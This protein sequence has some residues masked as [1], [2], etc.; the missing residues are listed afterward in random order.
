[1]TPAAIWGALIGAQILSLLLAWALLRAATR[2]DVDGEA[3]MR[4]ICAGRLSGD[5][6]CVVDAEGRIIA[7]NAPYAG[8]TGYTPGELQNTLLCALL[9]D[10]VDDP[11]TLDVIKTAFREHA[12][13]RTDM[14]YRARSGE[15][16]TMILELHP[17]HDR[18]KR[19]LGFGVVQID[20]DRQRH[21]SEETGRLL[22]H[23]QAVLDILDHYAIVSETD[24][25]GRIT[26]VNDEFIKLSGYSKAE[27]LGRPHSMLSSGHHDAQFW[28]EMWDTITQG[29]IWNNAVCNRAKNGELYWVHVAISPLLGPNGLPEKYVSI[30]LNITSLKVNRDLL[31]RTGQIARIGGWYAELGTQSVNFSREAVNILGLAFPGAVNIDDERALPDAWRELYTCIRKATAE[32][33]ALRRTLRIALPDGH[34]HAFRVAGEIEYLDGRPYRLIGAAQDITELLETRRRAQA[35]ER[36]LHSAIEALDEAFALYDAQEKLVFCNERYR[37]IAG[38]HGDRVVPGVSFEEVLRIGIE[39][40]A[41]LDA[42]HDPQAWLADQLQAMRGTHTSV[43]QHLRDGRWLDVITAVTEDGMRIRFCL[44]VTEMHRALDAAHMGMRSKSQFLA[45]MSHEIRTPMNAIIG[46][47]QLLRHAAVDVEQQDLLD[48]TNNAA[49]TLLAILNDILDFSKID[50]NQM[51]LSI[52]PFELDALLAELSVILSG[53]LGDRNLELIYDIDPDI[54]PVLRGDALRLKQVLMNLGSN[55]IKFT[56]SG[57]VVVRVRMLKLDASGA[58][59]EFAVEDTGIGI[60]AE[61]RPRIFNAFSQ[62]EASTSRRYGGTGLGLTISRR[63]IQLMLGQAGEGQDLDFESEPGRGSRFHFQILLPVEPYGTALSQPAAEMDAG[64]TA[65]LLEPH[66]H[67]AAALERMLA[68]MGWQVRI[69]RDA[70]A[71]QAVVRADVLDPRPRL[72]LLDLDTPQR[73]AF[74]DG[75]AALQ[76]NPPVLLTM[77]SRNL[78]VP[79]STLCKPV[80]AGMVL[81]A[82]GR[83]T[84]PGAA[85]NELPPAVQR[86]A[87]LHLLLV[88]DNSINQEVALRMLAREGAKV[89][90][91]AN[92]QLALDALDAEPHSYDLVLMDLHMPVLDGLQATR[93]IRRKPQ[94]VGLPIIAMTANAMESDR[95]ACLEAGMTDHIGKPFDLDKLVAIILQYTKGVQAPSARDITAPR[96]STAIMPILDAQ[97]G[98]TRVNHDDAFYARLL[99]D[100]TALAPAL[101]GKILDTQ[102]TDSTQIADAAHQLKSNAALVGALRLASVCESIEQT[103]RRA[104]ARV[105]DSDAR[106]SFEQTLSATLDAQNDWLTRHAQG[107]TPLS[108]PEDATPKAVDVEAGL[109]QLATHLAVCDMDSLDLFD[110]LTSRYGTTLSGPSWD[111]LQQAMAIF[112]TAAAIDAIHKLQKR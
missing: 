89:S 28:Q 1:M 58:L 71:L 64:T 51:Q 56:H 3:L 86:L 105:P 34:T 88:E 6:I 108:V 4:M 61:Q 27:L 35:S 22:R 90:V 17:M 10:S 46:M 48:K 30:H 33:K 43:H 77:S 50:A 67:S 5:A 60:S 84:T 87:G 81:T 109:D 100:F 59:L 53:N 14:R 47:L 11:A 98:L 8:L 57:E 96:S 94:H 13:I 104:P 65:W 20:I 76:D 52:E 7:T 36:T 75:L 40:N 78:N 38:T 54:P 79:R 103:L 49:H 19:L 106:Q 25:S 112:D 12:E 23:H 110:D 37:D 9:L 18:R 55:A 41:Y 69:F 66:L 74:L 72:V 44:D 92:G 83:H 68:G 101:G 85:R 32:R 99:R 63:L 39:A 70:D 80:T 31:A 26:Y 15:V 107:G 91:A 93:A 21:A 16:R 45:N 102:S 62:A 29:K 42:E 2:P 73:Q 82:L 111:A 24:L 95:H 97:A